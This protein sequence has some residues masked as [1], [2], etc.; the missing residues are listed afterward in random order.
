[1]CTRTTRCE[2]YGRAHSTCTH[3]CSRECSRTAHEDWWRCRTWYSLG[4]AG[5][6]RAGMSERTMSQV[7]AVLATGRFVTLRSS[8]CV[9]PTQRFDRNCAAPQTEFIDVEHS[10]DPV[11]ARQ[12]DPI[13]GCCCAGETRSGLQKQD[14]KSNTLQLL[15]FFCSFCAHY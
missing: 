3:V 4:H 10:W 14:S 9:W 7:R 15:A 12:G 13:H 1:M 11:V 6:Q 8:V 5:T 2:Q